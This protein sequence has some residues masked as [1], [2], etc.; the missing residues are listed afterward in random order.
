MRAGGGKGSC[1]SGST[2]LDFSEV[3]IVLSM[4][5]LV[6]LVRGTAGSGF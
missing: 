4:L 5:V 1:S 6:V 3:S 2:L